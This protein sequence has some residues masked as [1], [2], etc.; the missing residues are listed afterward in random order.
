MP[1]VIGLRNAKA[2]WLKNATLCSA[3]SVSTLFAY[4]RVTLIRNQLLVF[5]PSQLSR[6]PRYATPLQL[7][8][9]AFI[10]RFL[11]RFGFLSFI[12]YL[13]LALVTSDVPSFDSTRGPTLDSQVSRYDPCLHRS[14]AYSFFLFCL[15]TNGYPR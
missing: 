2:A 6:V 3:I 1:T 14:A 12:V 8:G 9:I 10:F 5:F 11:Y 4:L 7:S 15:S 13:R